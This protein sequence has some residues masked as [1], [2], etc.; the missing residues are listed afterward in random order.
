MRLDSLSKT[1][2]ARKTHEA[3]IIGA[4]RLLETPESMRY[5]RIVSLKVAMIVLPNSVT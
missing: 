4:S 1:G 5:A 2:K 3:S